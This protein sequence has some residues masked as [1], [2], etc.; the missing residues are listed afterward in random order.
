M[1]KI[2]SIILSLGMIFGFSSEAADVKVTDGTR[3][4]TVSDSV[5]PGAS[6][7]LVVVKSGESIENDNNIFAFGYSDADADGKISWSFTMPEKRDG[8]ITDGEY[9]LYIKQDDET[10]KTDSM[11]YASLESRNRIL[12]E[13][14]NISSAEGLGYILQNPLN[15]DVLKVTGFEMDIFSELSEYCDSISEMAYDVLKEDKNITVEKTAIAVNKAVAASGITNES[16][17][18]IY[19]GISGYEFEGASYSDVSDV[20]LKKWLCDLLDNEKYESVKDIEA[21]YKTANMLYIINNSNASVLE[22]KIS[23]YAELLG[24]DC[25]EYFDMSKSKRAKAD[26]EIREILHSNPAETASEL[27]RVIER[28]VNIAHDSKISGGGSSSGGGGGSSKGSSSISTMTGMTGEPGMAT[29]VPSNNEKLPFSDMEEARW[30]IDAVKAMA[31]KGIINGDENGNFRPNDVLTREEFVKMLVLAADFY[32]EN[33]ECSF[34]DTS[35]NLWHYTYIASGYNSG[36]VQGISE[37]EFGVSNLLTR[38]DMAALCSRA[39]NKKSGLEQ[40]RKNTFFDDDYLISDYAKEAVYDL[41]MA[42]MINGM[43]NGKFEPLS[44]ATRAQGAVII[45]NLFLGGKS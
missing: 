2:T 26:S 43:G 38:Q 9:D 3:R 12:D 33:A 14:K 19:L 41:Y 16:K 45:C 24:I 28:G 11:I 20:K 1:R 36:L 25:K 8:V 21:D 22:D 40:K 37:A 39:A 30:A 4:V 32:D 7:M 34:T 17:A 35:R 31:E 23:V 42:E 15:T 5:A 18:D 29:G 13:I 27:E 10:L 6:A 44:N